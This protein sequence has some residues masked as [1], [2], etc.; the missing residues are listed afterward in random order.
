MNPL[1]TT[2]GLMLAEEAWLAVSSAMLL[3]MMQAAPVFALA[4]LFMAF[5]T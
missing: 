2:L 1:M 3:P 4:V 5:P